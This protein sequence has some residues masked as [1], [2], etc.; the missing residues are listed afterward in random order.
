MNMKQWIK[1]ALQALF[2]ACIVIFMVYQ[3]FTQGKIN[4]AVEVCQSKGLIPMYNI[5]VH[6]FTCGDV[7]ELEKISNE[8]KNKLYNYTGLNITWS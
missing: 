6:N 7:P 1:D 4:G 2:I 5:S 3:S 8:W